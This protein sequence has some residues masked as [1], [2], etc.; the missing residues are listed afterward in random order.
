LTDFHIILNGF[1]SQAADSAWALLSSHPITEHGKYIN[2]Y[3]VQ[4]GASDYHAYV[5]GVTQF[6]AGGCAW[7]SQNPPSLFIM[8]RSQIQ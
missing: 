5:T 4:E 1:L 2:W 7:L 8:L 6:T 3:L